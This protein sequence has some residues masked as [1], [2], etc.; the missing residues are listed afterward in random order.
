MALTRTIGPFASNNFVNY[1]HT[2][3]TD[4][5]LSTSH[6]GDTHSTEPYNRSPA[7]TGISPNEN[8]S[9]FAM[10]MM[11]AALPGMRS[12]PQSYGYSQNQPRFTPSPQGFTP[13]QQTHFQPGVQPISPGFGQP[14]DTSAQYFAP[15]SQR[16]ALSPLPQ[17]FRQMPT[18]RRAPNQGIQPQL[19]SSPHVYYQTSY[20]TGN[21]S[22]HHLQ[23]RL[24]RQIEIGPAD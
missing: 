5:A 11:A 17:S 7:S 13:Q 20:G 12:S 14:V 3:S 16:Q 1:T 8:D 10:N 18:Q 21:S 4:P 19:Y 9:N 15:Y 6:M 24:Q 23:G 22:Q 2:A